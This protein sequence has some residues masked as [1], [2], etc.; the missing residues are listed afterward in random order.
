MTF[1]VIQSRRK[2]RY[3]IDNNHFILAV[4]CNNVYTLHCLKRSCDPDHAN[5]EVFCPS[6][7]WLK[8]KSIG[9]GTVIYSWGPLSAVKLG[10]QE[11][12]N[13]QIRFVTSLHSTCVSIQ[14]QLLMTFALCH[15]FPLPSMCIRWD[16]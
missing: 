11:N 15:A 3:S 10:P 2:R 8:L 16:T 12:E 9:G 13:L 14:L 6:K 7:Q 1:K 5:V 4:C